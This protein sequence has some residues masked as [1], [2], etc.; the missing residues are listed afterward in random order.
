MAN[1]FLVKNTMA[2]MRGLSTAEITALQNG[3]YNGVQLLGYY[4]KGDTPVPIIYYYVNPLTDPDPGPEDGGSVVAIGGIKLQHRFIGDINVLYFGC[5]ADYKDALSSFFDNT[6]YI[7][8][9]IN[10]ANS[11]TSIARSVS[12]KFNIIFPNTSNPYLGYGVN[13]RLKFGSGY[14]ITI[15]APLIYTGENGLAGAFLDIGDYSESERLTTTNR[16]YKLNARNKTITWNNIEFIGIKLNNIVRSTINIIECQGFDIGVQFKGHNAGF[17]YSKINLGNLSDNRIHADYTSYSP[18]GDSSGYIT[19]TV[20]SIY[21]RMGN[22]NF[23]ATKA[24][25]RIGIRIGF[26]GSQGYAP[27]SLTFDCGIIEGLV[28]TDT[29]DQY[30]GI[31]VQI[32]NGSLNTFNNFR[33]ESNFKTS[34]KPTF[35]QVKNGEGNLATLTI[36]V[37]EGTTGESNLKDSAFLEDMSS[38]KQGNR[39]ISRRNLAQKE[40]LYHN[41]VVF[42]SGLFS[43]NIIPYD[44]TGR[45]QIKNFGRVNSTG[46]SFR[47]L[48]PNSLPQYYHVD[49]EGYLNIPSG[50]GL[51]LEIDTENCKRFAIYPDEKDLNTTPSKVFYYTYGG[52][53]ETLIP[54]ENIFGVLSKTNV[55]T[56][57]TNGATDYSEEGKLKIKSSVRFISLSN[58]VKK[59][60]IIISG[61]NNTKIKSL[62]ILSL[63]GEGSTGNISIF[64]DDKFYAIEPP[65]SGNYK[66]G[67]IVYHDNSSSILGWIATANGS[68]NSIWKEIPYGKKVSTEGVYLAATDGTKLLGTL[69]AGTISSTTIQT[70]G[71]TGYPVSSGGAVFTFGGATFQRSMSL[72]IPNL[73]SNTT[74]YVQYYNPSGEGLKWH[75]INK[76]ALSVPNSAITPSSVYSQAEVQSILNE[77][78]DLKTS[79]RAAKLLAE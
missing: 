71:H 49:M 75:P 18:L 16:T 34:Q 32:N 28:N 13:G 51:F 25:D 17:A 8:N 20:T 76:Q 29:P 48:P 41:S 78:R 2:A 68:N 56:Y 70:T 57:G 43:K 77:L 11:I 47:D 74:H 33:H 6:P 37:P 24:F 61:L 31:P 58:D 55:D 19:S 60:R 4:E 64:A 69:I 38:L 12:C 22:S 54:S 30:R 21:G 46:T 26:Q 65:N 15:E 72:F 35:L 66:K 79:L 42:D 23:T 59:L 5:K 62:K 67:D 45:C 50:G 1:Q 40:S 7:I 14:D 10:Y 27:E 63:D 3:T 44:S 39:V 73:S 52:N 53:G 36:V 9:L